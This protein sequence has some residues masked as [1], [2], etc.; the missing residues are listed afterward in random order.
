MKNKLKRERAL[1]ILIGVISF[2]GGGMLVRSCTSSSD[3]ATNST[4]PSSIPNST[5]SPTT[6]PPSPIS[7]SPPVPLP[8]SSPAGNISLKLSNETVPVPSWFK[9]GSLSMPIRNQPRWGQLISYS[10]KQPP[11]FSQDPELQSVV[12]DILKLVSSKSLSTKN[13]SIVLIDANTNK[14]A[15][16]HPDKPHFPA[17]VAKMFWLVVLQGQIDKGMWNN[18]KAFDPFITKMMKESDNDSSS[19][20]IDQISDTQS[21]KTDLNPDQFNTWLSKRKFYINSF[22]EEAKYSNI[23]FTQKTYPIPYLDLQEP[24]GNELQVRIEPSNP[25][26]KPIRNQVSAMDAA[27]LMYEICYLKQ[28]INPEVSGRMCRLLQKNIDPK[29]WRS[30]KKEDFNPIETFFGAPLSYKNTEL[31]S[32]AGWTPNSRQEVAMIRMVD[33]KKEYILAVLADDPKYG[34]NNTIFPEISKLVNQK[35]RQ[36]K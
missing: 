24:K 5:Q 30:I 17:S 22:F 3:R 9:Q 20:I 21:S 10:L 7:V 33:R 34:K 19:F 25:K 11:Q 31:F 18:S 1:Y 2:I 27:R 29:S 14:F 36:N 28:A 16:H 8:A 15:G 6:V 26:P 4:P 32:K 13:L 35:L 23:N 12:G